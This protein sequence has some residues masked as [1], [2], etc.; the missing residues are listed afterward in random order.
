MRRDI[1]LYIGKNKKIRF[2]LHFCFSNVYFLSY[3]LIAIYKNFTFGFSLYEPEYA[4][5][6]TIDQKKMWTSRIFE[7]FYKKMASECSGKK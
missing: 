6:H 3:S 5:K 4:L 1:G 2:E 7:I